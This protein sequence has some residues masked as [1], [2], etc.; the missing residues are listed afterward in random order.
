[1]RP[2]TNAI[3]FVL[4]A[5][6]AV[7]AFRRARVHWGSRSSS[8]GLVQ[9]WRR[10]WPSPALS[11]GQ[12]EKRILGRMLGSVTPGVGGRVL[13]PGRFTITLSPADRR[14]FGD[15]LPLVVDGL[16]QELERR[17]ADKGWVLT[18]DPVV[19]DVVVD[20]EAYDGA[21]KVEASFGAAGTVS[22][23][24]P[25]V[26]G[27]GT[28]AAEDAATWVIDPDVAASTAILDGGASSRTVPLVT[29]EV[30]ITDEVGGEQ[31]IPLALSVEQVTLGRSSTADVHLA[32]AIVSGSHLA[33]V[34]TG[35]TWAVVD[36]GS[37]NGTFHNGVR[38][39]AGVPA[40]LADGDEVRIGRRGP[41]CRFVRFSPAPLAD[42]T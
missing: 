35:T 16:R 8:D 24:G 15:V 4:I 36:E 39:E 41:V 6:A 30:L 1:M 18:V 21:P 22:F 31:R 33:F 23:P 14:T 32:A 42:P 25:V 37:T 9:L 29:G 27:S 13:V 28:I 10:A 5:V 11:W 12:L 38:L 40:P 20:P 3:A 26:T 34:R 17:A 2:M 7:F 19:I